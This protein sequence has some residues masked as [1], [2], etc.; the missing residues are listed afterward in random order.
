MKVFKSILATVFFSAMTTAW[1]DTI[2][3]IG[4]GD[5]ATALGPQFARQGHKIVYGSRVRILANL[6]IH[7]GAS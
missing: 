2:A 5:V 1:A 3:I 6:I 7:S 4:S